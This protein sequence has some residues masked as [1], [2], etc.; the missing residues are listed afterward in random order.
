MLLHEGDR[1]R[2]VLFDETVR[3]LRQLPRLSLVL[4]VPTAGSAPDRVGV[5][6]I[7]KDVWSLR[8][9]WDLVLTPGGVELF[10]LQPSETNLFGTHQTIAGDFVLEPSATTFGVGYRIP[11]IGVS[12]VALLA[13][14]DVM[15]NRASGSPEGS[16]GHLIAGQ[17]LYSGLTEWAWDATTFWQDIVSRAYT[18]AAEK[19]YADPKTGV[20]VPF[21]YRA[22]DYLATYEL[23]RSFGWDT[24][25]DITLAAGINHT[26]YRTD[27][28]GVDPHAVADFVRA[29]VPVSDT[30]VGPSIQYETYTKRYVRVIDFDT[31]ALQED[32]RLGHDVLLRVHPSFRALGSSRDVVGLTAAAQYTFAHRSNRSP[33]RR[34]TESRTLRSS[35]PRTSCRPTSRGWAASSWTARSCTDGET[36]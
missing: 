31:L 1:Y 15:V 34:R 13:H 24:K 10:E 6:V 17:P 21:E 32:Y 27:L 28:P 11:R 9:N 33:I 3:N 23:R 36:T 26:V 20:K 2:Q 16:Y 30:R 29:E 8:L 22:R 7:T 12:R 14:A 18:D 5:V 19:R 25:H 35:R 4:A